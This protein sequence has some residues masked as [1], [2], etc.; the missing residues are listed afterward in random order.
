MLN[1]SEAAGRGGRIVF[2]SEVADQVL[3][4]TV[5]N[6]GDEILDDLLLSLND[7]DCAKP[8]PGNQQGLG[9]WVICRLVD[10]MGGK[11]EA[12]SAN[13]WTEVSVRFPLGDEAIEHAA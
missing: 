10:E 7:T 6:G 5:E 13:S 2:H 1:A 3:R 9:L 12:A 11:I 8:P 4:I